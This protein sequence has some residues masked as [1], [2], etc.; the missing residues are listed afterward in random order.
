[1]PEVVIQDEYAKA[2]PSFIVGKLPKEFSSTGEPVKE[3]SKP[4][5]PAE[6]PAIPETPKPE[7]EAASTPPETEEQKN[8]DPE[9][10]KETTG[11]DPEK[12]SSRRFERRIDRATRKA[13]EAEAKAAAAERRAA[14]L[15]ARL[16][17]PKVPEGAPKME[18]YTD[19][20]EYEKAARAHERQLAKKEFEKEQRESAL[21]TEQE[22]LNRG[23][24]DQVSK[25]VDKYD[26]FEDVVGDL[27]PDTAW[28]EAIMRADNGADIAH[29][30]GMHPKEAS[31]I[32]ALRSPAAQ[33]LEIG[34]LSVK[35]SQAT[36]A[37]KKPSKAPVPITPV[38]GGAEATG[39]SFAEPM[40]FEEYMK[41]GTK[42]F[43]G[44]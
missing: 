7:A 26:D 23:W 36:D 20:A 29:F 2:V 8:T 12:S 9:Q 37:P 41:V 28:K 3:V 35:L 34:K 40:P 13:A 43:R 30:L 24:E 39:K 38:T 17:A 1:M 42:M 31:R 15:E 6:A 27:R 19:V 14:E 25:A 10:D 11:K 5:V 4:E 44:R 16:N 32:H 33:V 22:E 21:K 18:D